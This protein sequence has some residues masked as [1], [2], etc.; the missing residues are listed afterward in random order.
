MTN[1]QIA[2]I[3]HEV[4]RIYCQSI[5]DNSQPAWDHA[6]DWQKDSAISGVAYL[7]ANPKALPEHSHRSWL[8]QKRAEGWVWGPVKNPECRMHPCMVEYDELPPSQQ[9][10][11]YFFHAVVRAALAGEKK[12]G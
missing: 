7:T 4:N 6:P 2:R 12:D 10:K 5:G 1:E 8:A 3:A 11:D 9:Y